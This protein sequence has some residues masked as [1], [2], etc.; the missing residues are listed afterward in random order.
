[1]K[2]KFGKNG[3]IHPAYGRLGRGNNSG[4]WYTLPAVFGEKETITVP[5]MDHTSKPPR[6]VGE[7]EITRYKYLPQSAE[8]LED[9]DFEGMKK[10]IEEDGDEPPKA[11]RPKPASD[12]SEYLPAAQS[13]GK[14]QSAA[15]RTTG[16]NKPR[17]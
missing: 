8:V 9:D 10:E 15:E 3:F 5:L 7:K 12:A 17:N 16:K 13:K 6:K 1:M 14:A 2:V 4:Q 11:I